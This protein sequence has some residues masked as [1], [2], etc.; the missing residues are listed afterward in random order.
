MLDEG[1][2]KADRIFR[3]PTDIN[4]FKGV[5]HGFRRFGDALSASKRWDNVIDEGIKWVLSNPAA[6]NS[7]D[8]K[9]Q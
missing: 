8:V 6:T 2:M 7:F 1:V 9:E 3:V 4:V 5:P